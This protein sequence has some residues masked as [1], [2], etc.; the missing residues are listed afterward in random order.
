MAFIDKVKTLYEKSWKTFIRPSRTQYSEYQLPQDYTVL[1]D[2]ITICRKVD[3]QIPFNQI[4]LNTSLFFPSS[5]NIEPQSTPFPP[6]NS[7][8]VIYLHSHT[9]SKL[10]GEDLIHLLLPLGISVC[11]FDFGG[12]GNSTGK[13]VSLGWHETEE[14]LAVLRTIKRNYGFERVALWGKSMGGCAAIF[15]ASRTEEIDALVLDSPFAKLNN[16][17]KNIAGKMVKLP[18]FIIDG[19]LRLIRNSIKSEHNFD[20]DRVNPIE[21][22][23]LISIPALFVTGNE[24][25]IVSGGSFSELF[26]NYAGKDKL[27]IVVEGNHA[28][29]RVGDPLFDKMVVRFLNSRLKA[30]RRVESFD[31]NTTINEEDDWDRPDL[32]ERRRSLEPNNGGLSWDE[33]GRRGLSLRMRTEES[34]DCSLREEDFE[35]G[36]FNNNYMKLQ[37]RKNKSK[38]KKSNLFF[39]R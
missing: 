9:G 5:N 29:Q 18:D 4:L 35:Q 3:L 27:K 6:P 7:P 21:Y 38:R 32:R 1:R 15:L 10:E 26:R 20:I 34:M 36:S 19:A 12:A 28:D 33:S 2:K 8:V 31:R 30:N 39:M 25:S 13:Y 16:V 14:T 24:D 23:G 37:K 17:V 11:L 22:V